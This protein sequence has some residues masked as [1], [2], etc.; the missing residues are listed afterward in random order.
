MILGFLIIFGVAN[1]SPVTI[2]LARIGGKPLRNLQLQEEGGTPRLAKN[3]MVNNY[4][5]RPEDTLPFANSRYIGEREN[6]HEL[7]LLPV[8]RGIEQE[9]LVFPNGRRLRPSLKE[10]Y[11]P[12]GPLDKSGSWSVIENSERNRVGISVNIG[13]VNFY[14]Q[15]STLFGNYQV[16]ILERSFR[17]LSSSVSSFL[18]FREGVFHQAFLTPVDVALRDSSSR[19]DTRENSH[20]P[21]GTRWILFALS[22][23]FFYWSVDYGERYGGNTLIAISFGFFATFTLLFFLCGFRWS[24]G[25]WL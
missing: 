3:V 5:A 12:L 22:G 10:E 20:P 15:A 16:D 24:W 1:F 4:S 9:I 7:V 8:E 2:H 14:P 13:L 18:G 19:N 11:P 23:A 21:I 25:W 17:T 6:Q